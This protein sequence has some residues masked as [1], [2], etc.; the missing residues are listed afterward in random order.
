MVASCFEDS[1]LGRRNDAEQLLWSSL[2]PSR[3]TGRHLGTGQ[4]LNSLG[5]LTYAQGRYDEA[6]AFFLEA[7]NQFRE[8][9]DMMSLSRVLS[10][11]G[12]NFLALQKWSMPE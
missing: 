8:M 4:E 2:E 1:A 9:S 5:Q 11:Q 6:Q 7:A 3:D 12:L 10:H